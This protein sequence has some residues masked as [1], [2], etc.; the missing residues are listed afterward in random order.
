M[1]IPAII[2]DDEEHARETIDL[3][4]E[5]YCPELKIAG[6]AN[7]VDE[8]VKL[9]KKHNP[10]IIFLDINMPGKNGFELFNEV[11]LDDIK[12][13]FTTAY[14]EFAIKA[15]NLSASYYLLK[16]ISPVDFKT[17]VETTIKKITTQTSDKVNLLLIKELFQKQDDYPKKLIVNSKNGYEIVE[18]ET[19][20]YFEGDKNYTWINT[21]NNRYLVAKTLKEYENLLNPVH[22]FRTH[23]SHLVNKAFI[24]KVIN[25]RPDQIELT[26]GLQLNLSRDK[27]KEFLEWLPI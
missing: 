22:F 17:A 6:K 16:P 20:I 23:Q 8:G 24:K 10:Q 13:I 1:M 15:I 3:L 18:I 27:K 5:K 12:I 19:I 7:S 11:N 25:N 4:T 14:S 9:I 21:E 26:N 2:I